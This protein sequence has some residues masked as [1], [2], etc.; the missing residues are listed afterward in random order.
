MPIVSVTVDREGRI[1]CHPDPVVVKGADAL[2]SFNLLT[3][4]YAFALQGAIVVKN[5]GKDFPI[6]SWTVQSS[7]AALLDLCSFSAEYDYG[8]TVLEAAT[9]KVLTVDPGIKNENP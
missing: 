3:P 2:L 5:P 6:P 7:S 8:V 9:G 4:G 1:S